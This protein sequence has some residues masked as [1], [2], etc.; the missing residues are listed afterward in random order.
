MPRKILS[1][2]EL[3]QKDINRFWSKLDTSDPNKCW[4]WP[5]GNGIYGKFRAEGRTL[6]A[7]KI[8]FYLQ[9]GSACFSL[10]VCHKCDTPRCC[11]GSH[12]FAGTDA[13]NQKDK[14]AKGRSSN[15]AIKRPDLLARGENSGQS[16]LTEAQVLEIRRRYSERPKGFHNGGSHDVCIDGATAL[17]KEFGVTKALIYHI[18]WR[19]VWAHIP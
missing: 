12:L 16:K 11:N 9:N 3:S 7:H 10:L 17:A 14:S 8:A 6:A 2:P 1:I 13:E 18:V 19:K 5:G 4:L 15:C